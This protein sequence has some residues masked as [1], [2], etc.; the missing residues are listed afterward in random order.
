MFLRRRFAAVTAL[1]LAAVLALAGC[2]GAPLVTPTGGSGAIPAEY[3][4][5]YEQKLSWASCGAKFQCATATAPLDWS[6]PSGPT[7]SL[8][9]IKH[10]AS[11]STKLGSL[12]VN[13]GGPGGSGVSFVRDSLDFAVDKQVQSAYDVIGFDPR[14]VGS[15]TPI[16]CLTDSKRMDEWVFGLNPNERFSAAWLASRQADAAEF[17]ATCAAKTGELIAHVDTVSA[18]R[19]LD[20]LRAAVGDNVFNY[21]GYSY[22]TLLGATYADQFP[23]RVGRM[24][25]DGA[26]DPAS[27]GTEVMLTQAIGFENALNSYLKWCLQ[28]KQCPFTASGAGHPGTTPTDAELS[29]ARDRISLLLATLDRTPLTGTDGRKVGADTM[30]TAIITPLY[31]KTQWPAL[32]QIFIAVMQGKADAA[33]SSADTYYNRVNGKYLD[34]ST[35]AF[36]AIN[37]LDYPVSNSVTSW[38]TDAA[39]LVKAAPVLGPYLSYGD[40][41]CAAWPAKATRVPAPVKAIGSPDILVVGTTGDPATPYQWAVNLSKELPNGHLLTYVGEGHTAY[42]KGSSCVNDA[43]DGF[44][45]SGKVPL[46][47]ARC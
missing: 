35:E 31:S 5:F 37:C 22:G 30:V 20:M 2:A 26:L 44:L 34:N 13:P 7:I 45:L 18:A 4:P 32:T 16:T 36:T 10:A 21:L 12:F 29:S 24:V 38:A 14:G 6:K 8:A 15:S 3:T 43:V 23:T 33:L 1:T 11:G 46:A 19:D 9:L 25:L 47:D 42:N 27:S 17:S 28:Q 39:A 40:A 41:L